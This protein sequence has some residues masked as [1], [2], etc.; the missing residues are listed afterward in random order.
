MSNVSS[1]AGSIPAEHVASGT[2]LKGRPV[3]GVATLM[4]TASDTSEPHRPARWIK[5][6]LSSRARVCRSLCSKALS[7]L[8]S[9]FVN[10]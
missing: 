9:T 1:A 2:V 10:L 8:S 6:I 3:A 7:V 4:P 5:S